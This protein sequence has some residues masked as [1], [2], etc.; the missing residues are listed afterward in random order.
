MNKIKNILTKR[1]EYLKYLKFTSYISHPTY[2][3]VNPT[4]RLKQ[5]ILMRDLRLWVIENINHS[6]STKK[7]FSEIE[8]LTR[9]L[10]FIEMKTIYL[11]GFI[12]LLF[13][14]LLYIR[15]N[16]T[17]R[18]NQQ[19][20]WYDLSVLQLATNGAST[21]HNEETKHPAKNN[22]VN[23]DWFKLNIK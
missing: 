11:R 2:N 5:L 6:S 23:D 4:S 10:R 19:L 7:F 15:I 13:I 9:E 14:S 1:N 12:Y 3:R 21:L 22:P 17:L 20:T 18:Q 8:H 16:N